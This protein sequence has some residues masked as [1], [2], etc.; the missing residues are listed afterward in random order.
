MANVTEIHV[1][2]AKQQ[3]HTQGNG[4]QLDDAGDHQQHAP[5]VVSVC[6]ETEQ[7][8]HAKIDG[9]RNHRAHSGG[10]HDDVVREM[11]FTK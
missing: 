11:N 10:C 6:K 8:H 1:Q 7:N 4:I 2:R 5:R 3:R 9:Q